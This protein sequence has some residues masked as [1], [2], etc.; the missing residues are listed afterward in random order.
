[1]V[2]CYLGNRTI[3]FIYYFWS[4]GAGSGGEVRTTRVIN[5]SDHGVKSTY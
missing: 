2:L 1:M 4:K 3:D 5:H